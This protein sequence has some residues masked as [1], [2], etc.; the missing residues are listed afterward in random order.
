MKEVKPTKQTFDDMMQKAIAAGLHGKGYPK[1][2]LINCKDS[3]GTIQSYYTTTG[4]AIFRDGN[5]RDSARVT[6]RN[7]PFDRFI[8]LCI[9]KD[10]DI[11]AEYF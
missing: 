5:L 6:V 1:T 8:T 7:L 3:D 11:L 4:T 2:G 10:A 9:G